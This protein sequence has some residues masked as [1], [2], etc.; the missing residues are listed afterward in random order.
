MYV[1]ICNAITDHQVRQAL[2]QGKES[3]RDL[4]DHLGVTSTCGK[5]AKCVRRLLKEHQD[6]Q[7]STCD[8]QP[9]I[10]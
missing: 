9:C 2:S 10:A 4:R 5:C 6:T 3:M 8:L 1:C 7:E